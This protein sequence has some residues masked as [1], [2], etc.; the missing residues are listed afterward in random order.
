[1]IEELRS[2]LLSILLLCVFC[3]LAESLMPPGAIQQVGKLVCGLVLLCGI[4]TPLLDL[5]IEGSQR[6]MEEWMAQ[7][8]GEQTQ[9][10]EE[11][12]GISKPIIEEKYAAYIVDKAKEQGIA[13][14]VQVEAQA[15]EGEEWFLPW[16]VWITGNISEEERLWLTQMVQDDLEVPAQR[17]IYDAQE[18][19]P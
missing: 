13:C 8:E 18:E 11:V 1:M 14:A 17:Q 6:W 15:T 19:V 3:A 5:D 12:Q 16:E 9:L 7:W 10:E 4:I 2:W